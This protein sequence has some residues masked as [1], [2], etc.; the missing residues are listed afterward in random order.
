M[1]S[2]AKTIA[3]FAL[4]M[5]P[6]GAILVVAPNFLLP[7]LG[8][9]PTDEPWI[10]ILGMFMIVVS[11]YYY[12]AATSEATEFFRATVHGRTVMAL[13]LA[14]LGIVGAPVLVLFAAAELL[15][16]VITALALRAHPAGSLASPDMRHVV[17]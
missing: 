14:Y 8:L 5:T 16:A 10:R 4:Y 15:G 12:R 1:S 2:A 6:V 11:Y 13:F 3:G 17:K 9:P 7:L